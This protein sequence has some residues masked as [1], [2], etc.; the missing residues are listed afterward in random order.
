MYSDNWLHLSAEFLVATICD[1]ESGSL[2]CDDGN[3][4]SLVWA[5]YGRVHPDTCTDEGQMIN[6]TCRADVDEIM[7]QVIDS[8]SSNHFVSL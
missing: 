2:S 4:I 5:N 3:V 6:V 8:N 7:T 1:G